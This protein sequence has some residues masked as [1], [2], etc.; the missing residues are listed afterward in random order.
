MDSI[1]PEQIVSSREQFNDVSVDLFDVCG[2]WFSGI[3]SFDL[4]N[5]SKKT[6]NIFKK[7][8]YWEIKEELGRSKWVHAVQTSFSGFI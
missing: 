5:T 4:I 2:F 3:M 1:G 8:I 7:I 6:T